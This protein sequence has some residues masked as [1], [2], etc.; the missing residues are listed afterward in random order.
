MAKTK[1]VTRESL[2]ELVTRGDDVAMHAIGRALVHLLN[3]QTN[4]EARVNTT[5]NRN[6]V[7]FTPADGKSGCIGAKYY[8][9]WKKLEPWMIKK[10]TEE[11][12]RGVPRIAKYWS[13]LNEEAQRKAHE[14]S[15]AAGA[16]EYRRQSNGG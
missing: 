5:R 15:V 10:W 2:T 8:I 12:V 14:A 9:K 1:L 7:G 3:R 13:Q 6:D 11:N 16:A 4:Y